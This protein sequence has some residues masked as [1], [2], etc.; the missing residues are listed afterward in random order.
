MILIL[1]SSSDNNINVDIVYI[2][3]YSDVHNLVNP[4][5]R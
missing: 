3:W 4:V 5:E 2:N 1:A